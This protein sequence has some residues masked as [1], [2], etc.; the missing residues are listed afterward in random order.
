MLVHTCT[1]KAKYTRTKNNRFWA[2]HAP[3]DRADDI[4]AL[5]GVVNHVLMRAEMTARVE[6]V[7]TLHAVKRPHA[8]VTRRQLRTANIISL[9]EITVLAECSN[10]SIDRA[11]AENRPCWAHTNHGRGIL[12]CFDV[13]LHN[14]QT[15]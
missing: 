12:S 3:A 9:G 2:T 15:V 13:G 11:A 7:I 5:G 1:S 8:V 14:Y 10:I 4:A 6:D